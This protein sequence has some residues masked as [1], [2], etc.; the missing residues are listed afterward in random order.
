MPTFSL[1]EEPWIPVRRLDGEAVELS[2]REVYR[3]AADLADVEVESPLTYSALMRLLVVGLYAA[4]RDE[5]TQANRAAWWATGWPQPAVEAY[6]DQWAERFDLFDEAAPF[7]QDPGFE[8]KQPSTPAGLAP[9]LASGNNRVLFDHRVDGDAPP[10]RAAAAARW[11]LTHQLFSLG[12]GNG[13]ISP[14]YGK[15]P[16]LRTAPAALGVTVFVQGET[17]GQTLLL[18]LAPRRTQAE[19]LGQPIWECAFPAPRKHTVSGLLGRLTWPN[20]TVRLVTD[21]TSTDAVVTGIYTAQCT[22]WPV[23][24][25]VGDPYFAWRLTT[26]GEPIPLRV[27]TGRAL[28]RDSSALF[29]ISGQDAARAEGAKPQR[30]WVLA[31]AGVLYDLLDRAG[32]APEAEWTLVAVGMAS[33]QSKIELW[34]HEELPVPTRLLLGD[35]G[36]GALA[37]IDDAVQQAERVFD[38]L[39]TATRALAA[40]LVKPGSTAPGADDKAD[41]KQVGSRVAAWN[42]D[43]AYWGQLDAP[44]RALLA[45][46]DKA[47]T[48]L[49]AWRAVL[50]RAADDAY[51]QASALAGLDPRALRAVTLGRQAVTRSWRFRPKKP[52]KGSS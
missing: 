18:N 10:V 4:L 17:L 31:Q 48:A 34:R 46:L 47:E 3:Q 1:L 22:D 39:R 33:D 28:W 6:F 41:P 15:H 9:E 24:S 2:W 43:A 11:L 12:G 51:A 42:I 13:P 19:P 44:F 50:E 30:P 49:T 45:G 16:N 52:K 38:A 35:E 8:F 37:V 21:A 36:A 32:R 7:F 20:R 26:K 27:T 40:E 5:V 29:G 23:T 14:R 25:P